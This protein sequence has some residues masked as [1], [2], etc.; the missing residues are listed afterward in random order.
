MLDF[1]MDPCYTIEKF[2]NRHRYPV[3]ERCLFYLIIILICNIVYKKV[4]LFTKA[5]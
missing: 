4:M 5:K 3:Q 2:K 1:L